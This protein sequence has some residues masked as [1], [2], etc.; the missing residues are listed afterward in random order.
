M[1]NS[2]KIQIETEAKSLA[3]FY[4]ITLAQGKSLA[5]ADYFE[6]REAQ[7]ESKYQGNFDPGY[8]YDCYC[9]DCNKGNEFRAASS[10]RLFILDHRNHKTKTFRRR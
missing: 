2:F 8:V 5:W 4:G 6:N 9:V 10:I 3:E 1:K 7:I